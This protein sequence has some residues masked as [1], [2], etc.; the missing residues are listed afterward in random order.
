MLVKSR[1]YREQS[2]RVMI[3]GRRLISDAINSGVQAHTLF[4]SQLQ[5]LEGIPLHKTRAVVVKVPYR[6]ITMWSDVVTPQGV[7]GKNDLMACIVEVHVY[8]VTMWSDVVTPQGVIGKNDL[9]AFIVEVHVYNEKG[10][11]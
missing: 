5:S 10:L 3:E 8:P 2:G 1:K 9:M 6:E 11:W 7:I 4:F